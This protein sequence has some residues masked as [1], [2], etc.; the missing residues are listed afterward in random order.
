MMHFTE[1]DL[2]IL[3]RCV[4]GTFFRFEPEVLVFSSHTFPAHRITVDEKKA[5]DFLADRM[6]AIIDMAQRD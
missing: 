2:T 5:R 6:Q 3:G 4:D 1:G